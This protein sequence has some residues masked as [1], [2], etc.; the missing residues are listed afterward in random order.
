MAFLLQQP[1]WTGQTL[2]TALQLGNLR[3]PLESFCYLSKVMEL[4]K[5]RDEIRTPHISCC[6][7]LCHLVKSTL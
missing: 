1:E 3:L 4:E 5:S 7:V 2:A 6:P